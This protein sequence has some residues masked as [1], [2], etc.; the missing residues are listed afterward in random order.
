MGAALSESASV[1]SSA[2]LMSFVFMGVRGER[3]GLLQ[4]R[5]A[6]R[7]RHVCAGEERI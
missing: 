3:L 6:G 5:A 7:N 4:A 1:S 2:P